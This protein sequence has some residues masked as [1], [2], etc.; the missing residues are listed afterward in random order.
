MKRNRTKKTAST[1]C[2]SCGK[3]RKAVVM[4]A[5]GVCVFCFFGEPGWVGS[6]GRLYEDSESS[7]DR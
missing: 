3:K 4:H 6:D 2:P 7:M 1:V 5:T